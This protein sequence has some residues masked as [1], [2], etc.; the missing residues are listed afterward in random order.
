MSLTSC[1]LS[2]DLI[3][4]LRLDELVQK[5]RPVLARLM[6]GQS[7]IKGLLNGPRS[8]DL[9]GFD[10]NLVKNPIHLVSDCRQEALLVCLP[11]RPIVPHQNGVSK[12]AVK[13]TGRR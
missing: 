12:S 10:G 4:A 13:S 8:P 1:I 9:A 2:Y 5:M 6:A 7:R 3:Q 11:C